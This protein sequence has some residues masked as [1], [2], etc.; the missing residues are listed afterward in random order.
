MDV[1]I[2]D[3]D[4]SAE[5]SDRVNF[6]ALNLSQD[7]QN[8][9]LADGTT[10]GSP[11][12]SVNNDFS[13]QTI[14][15]MPVDSPSSAFHTLRTENMSEARPTSSNGKRSRA[16]SAAP[17]TSRTNINEEVT[18]ALINMA[19]L[20]KKRLEI[21]DEMF[22]RDKLAKPTIFSMDECFAKLQGLPNL[23]AD[24]MLAAME[25]FKDENNN[26]VF[27]HYEG[28]ML[29]SWMMRQL[30]EFYRMSFSPTGSS[31]NTTPMASMPST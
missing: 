20:G 29:E 24:M 16:S 23:T 6:N 11:Y 4:T 31:A 9:S 15:D 17:N 26:W 13:D 3:E 22:R 2:S 21:I 27:M 19:E 7:T 8:K 30:Y 28:S 14:P 18:N 12:A 25:S 10:P 5:E 1:M